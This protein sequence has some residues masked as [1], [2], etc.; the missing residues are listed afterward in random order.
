M[1]KTILSALLALGLFGFT[2]QAQVIHKYER[3]VQDYKWKLTASYNMMDFNFNH[4]DLPEGAEM[5]AGGIPVKVGI[6]YEF[7]PN[8]SIEADF[9]MNEMEV[10]NVMNGQLIED[11]NITITSFNGSFSYSLGGLFNIPIADPYIK[12]GFG[13]L[14]LNETDLTMASAGGGINIWIADIRATK[15]AHYHHDRIYRRFGINVEAMGRSNV[16]TEGV[17]S[18]AQYSAGIFYIF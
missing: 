5:I 15:T 16:S 9:S 3:F 12:A 6:G 8:L 4:T 10:G 11:K 13:H 18:H 14:R 7:L 17:G 2:A 1:K